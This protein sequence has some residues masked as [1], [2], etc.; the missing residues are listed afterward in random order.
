MLDLNGRNN[1]DLFWSHLVQ[2]YAP[3]KPAH[4]PSPAD[5]IVHASYEPL[6]LSLNLDTFV[7]RPRPLTMPE[8]QQN[9]W[10]P[11]EAWLM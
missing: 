6:S 1:K 9:P 4:L 8:V 3:E 11:S 10:L 2:H 5:E 7:F